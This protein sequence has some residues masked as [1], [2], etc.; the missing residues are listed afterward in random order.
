MLLYSWGRS[1]L[2]LDFAAQENE[3]AWVLVR[4]SY[5]IAY[6]TPVPQSSKTPNTVLYFS[7]NSENINLKHYFWINRKYKP[8]ALFPN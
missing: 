3:V 5:T 4:E 7:S 1:D 2:E 6:L 8:G